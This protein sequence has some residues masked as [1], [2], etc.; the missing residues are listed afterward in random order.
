LLLVLGAGVMVVLLGYQGLPRVRKEPVLGGTFGKHAAKL[1]RRTIA[2]AALFGVGW[3]LSGVCPGPAIAGL[4]TGNWALAW[5]VAGLFAGAWV[6]GKT[7]KV[8]LPGTR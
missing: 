2:G 8:G 4:G 7:A 6:Q 3:G 1:D 5:A